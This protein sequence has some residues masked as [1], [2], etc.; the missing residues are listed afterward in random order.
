MSS[1]GEGEIYRAFI[2][3]KIAKMY[4]PGIL[5][6]ELEEKLKLMIGQ[7]PG[8]TILSQVAWPTDILY[9]ESGKCC[10][11]LMQELEIN[12]ELGDIYK[13]PSRR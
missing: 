10:G 12:A 11:F 6:K 5:T 3:K 8:K 7:P 13:Y 9:N 1:G 2:I 4:N